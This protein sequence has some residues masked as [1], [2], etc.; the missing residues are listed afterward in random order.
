MKNNL[1]WIAIVGLFLGACASL[2]TDYDK[3]L[4]ENTEF[5]SGVKVQEIAPPTTPVASGKE[6]TA[7]TEPAQLIEKAKPT[8]P[9]PSKQPPLIKAPPQKTKSKKTKTI[10]AEAKSLPLK[11]EPSL[12]D[13][14]GF[15]GRRPIVEPFVE[16]EEL[17]YQLSYFA[18][19]AGRLSMKTSPF[20][21][22]NGRKSYRF[23][24]HARSSS[25][26]SLFYTVDDRAESFLDYDELI[27]YSYTISA[28]ET[29]QIRDVKTLFN[30]QTMRG[31]TWDK[32]LKKG[33]REPEEKIY[34]WEILPYSQN[35][36]TVAYYMRCFHYEVGKEIS[37]RVA[38]E[39]T[40]II[41]T[42]KIL[43]EEKLKTGAGVFD[44]FVIK[45]EFEIDGVFKKVGD[46][47]MWITN[48]KYHRIAR[49]ESK[50]KIGKVVADLVQI[51]P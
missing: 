21:Q 12:E 26:F 7:P 1:F 18:V 35:V 46:V 38:H 31:K 22:V 40:N 29:K 17:T 42:A 2:Y 11:H 48:D 16:G 20:V 30:W 4:L 43:R 5:D 9:A 44:T 27:P 41:M 15:I 49:I 23:N 47:F 32:K 28:R 3:T 25:V 14:A 37:V 50:I 8:P 39:G 19:E 45:P 34:D 33:H 24:L 13:G 51:S 36:V 6:V 10:E